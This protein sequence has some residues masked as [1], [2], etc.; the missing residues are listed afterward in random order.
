M[1]CR[2]RTLICFWM[3]HVVFV[4]SPT[5]SI[6]FY[7]TFCVQTSAP[8]NSRV[9]PTPTILTGE[10]QDTRSGLSFWSDY[11]DG[12]KWR[13]LKAIK[14]PLTYTL[15]FKPQGSP[16]CHRYWLSAWKKQKGENTCSNRAETFSEFMCFSL[17]HVGMFA[18]LASPTSIWLKAKSS[19]H[20]VGQVRLAWFTEPALSSR[21]FRPPEPCSRLAA[22]PRA[23][24]GSDT[25][26]TADRPC[27]SRCWPFRFQAAHG[28]QDSA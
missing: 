18:C 23:Q 7:S 15:K 21:L 25:E 2:T 14:L 1:R 17:P 26:P 8:A 4:S 3:S 5:W 16:S 27:H 12:W 10:L 9:M 13:G 19:S 22:S 28:G 6:A 20:R 11:V 24:A